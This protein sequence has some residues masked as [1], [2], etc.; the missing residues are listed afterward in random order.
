MYTNVCKYKSGYKVQSGTVFP[1]RL[2]KALVYQTWQER[3][4]PLFYCYV[5]PL[6]VCIPIAKENNQHLWWLAESTLVIYM[7]RYTSHVRRYVG[8]YHIPSETSYIVK[9]IF[10]TIITMKPDSQWPLTFVINLRPLLDQDTQI[11]LGRLSMQS[12]GE[13]ECRVMTKYLTTFTAS[14]TS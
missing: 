7:G 1:S 10:Q 13:E 6:A 14:S 4:D 8:V 12:E 11:S 5:V 2:R 3:K 9:A